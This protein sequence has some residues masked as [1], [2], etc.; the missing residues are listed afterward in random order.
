MFFWNVVRFFTRELG[1]KISAIKILSR[2]LEYCEE[3]MEV[4]ESALDT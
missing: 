3:N 1:G 4:I 2:Q